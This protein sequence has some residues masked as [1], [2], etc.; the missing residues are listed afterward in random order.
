MP[1]QMFWLMNE[2]EVCDGVI[3][4]GHYWYVQAKRL[5]MGSLLINDIN[6]TSCFNSELE[7]QKHFIALFNFYLF[8]A[9]GQ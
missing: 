1:F 8:V 5:C 2:R 9:V 4:C 7:I 3:A 6:N